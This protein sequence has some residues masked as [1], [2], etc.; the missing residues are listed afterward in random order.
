MKK[1]FYL[2][3]VL[4]GLFVTSCSDDDPPL[5]DNTVNFSA[6][7]LGISETESSKSFTINIDRAES[8]DVT[9][10][11]SVTA[12]GV[13]YGEDFTTTP[14]TSGNAISATIKAGSTSATVEVKKLAE[15]LEGDESITFDISSA[16]GGLVLGDKKSLKLTFGAIVST[17]STMTLQGGEG[18]PAAVNSVFVDFS[19]N[20]QTSVARVSWNLGLYNGSEFGVIMN[21]TLP[22]TAKVTDLA[23]DAVISDADAATYQ[24]EL[25]LNYTDKFA[26]LDDLS[27]D[28][29]KSVIKEEGKVYLVNFAGLTPQLYKVKISKKDAD[30]Y[31]VQYAASNSSSVK[32]IDVAKNTNYNFTYV[33]FTDN[34]I[35]PVEPEKN[36][37]DIEWTRAVN[38]SGTIP[39]IF[40]DLVFI[41]IHAGV[42]AA[43]ILGDKDDYAAYDSSKLSSAEFSSDIQAI[44]SKWRVTASSTEPLGIRA[45]RFY[46]V[47]DSAGNVYK[48]RFLRMGV[49]AGDTGTR[50]YPE[51]EYALVK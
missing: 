2:S 34:K 26:Y 46:L 49:G 28:L 29:S 43:E 19:G 15:L 5:A 48:L 8:S 38:K 14:A 24:T 4:A 42:T 35:V 31:T 7:E 51:I 11:I 22:T 1:F 13:V 36:K 47:K 10:N 41:N 50:G 16:T 40:S 9:V 12:A 20:E 17:G 3:L 44:G 33:S 45:D 6:T 27:G 23:I 39:Y 37:W 32:S 21:N 30:T 18:G 25:T